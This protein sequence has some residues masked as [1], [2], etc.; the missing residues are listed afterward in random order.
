MGAAGKEELVIQS[1]T[2]PEQFMTGNQK[3]NALS[4]LWKIRDCDAHGTKTTTTTNVWESSYRNLQNMFALKKQR[5]ASVVV[6]KKLVERVE[7]R[8]ADLAK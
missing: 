2:Q 6:S 8:S 7:Y 5:S 4:L 1:S 3:S